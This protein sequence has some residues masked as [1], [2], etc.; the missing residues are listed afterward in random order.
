[1]LI[2]H[3]FISCALKLTLSKLKT[4][5]VGTMVKKAR[6]NLLNQAIKIYILSCWFAAGFV[7]PEKI[8][9]LRRFCII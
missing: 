2:Q 5:K 9:N 8:F 1:M 7:D 6:K 3:F 4:E